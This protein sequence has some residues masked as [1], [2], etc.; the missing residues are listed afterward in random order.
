MKPRG[1]TKEQGGKR[2]LTDKQKRGYIASQGVRCPYCESY[3]ID[4]G[5]MEFEGGVF[6]DVKCNSCGETWSDEYKLIDV[7]SV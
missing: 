4:A 5:Q 1:T 3:D 2:M 7:L 6:Q